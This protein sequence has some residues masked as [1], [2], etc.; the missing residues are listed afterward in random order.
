[1]LNSITQS[2]L[3]TALPLDPIVH[4]QACVG[5]L[6]CPAAEADV[7]KNANGEIEGALIDGGWSAYQLLAG[8][9]E[10]V[11]E[12]LP[13][14]PAQSPAGWRLSFPEW[15]MRDVAE[16]WPTAQRSFE[17]FHVCRAEDYCPPVPSA[18]DVMRLTPYLVERYV[19]DLELV[20]ALCGLTWQQCRYPLYAAIADEQVVSMADGTAMT[21]LVALVQQVYTVPAYRRHGLAKAVVARLTEEIL[22]LGRVC[23]YTADYTNHASLSLCRALGY[24]PI[25]VFGTAELEG[26]K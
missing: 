19:F 25:A 22:A 20:K 9:R 6:Q 12:L 8:T 24:R 4:V 7:W 16:L 2:Q 1:M 15:A 17:I 21:E 5:C 23:A 3:L 18:T 26:D 13:R 14:L 11:R 10:A